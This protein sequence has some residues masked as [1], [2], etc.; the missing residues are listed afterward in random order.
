MISII[1]CG[2]LSFGFPPGFWRCSCLARLSVSPTW[3]AGRFCASCASFSWSCSGSWWRGRWPCVRTQ[4]GTWHW[5]LWASL[6]RV[7]SS[8]CVCWIAG[9][10][11]WQWVRQHHSDSEYSV[12][13]LRHAVY[14]STEEEKLPLHITFMIQSISSSNRGKT[15]HFNTFNI[16]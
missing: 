6:Q 1:C 8:V 5:S 9:I 12:H 13:Y 11:W 7:W 16:T 4:T 15:W 10:T 2:S 14:I 3:P